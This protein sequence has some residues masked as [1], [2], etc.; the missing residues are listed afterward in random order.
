MTRDEIIAGLLQRGAKPDAARQ[1]ADAYVE[2]QEAADRV[3]TAGLIVAH[4]VTK[5]P[6]EN[7]YLSIR[8]KALARLQAMRKAAYIDVDWLW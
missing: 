6:I 3:T 8:D 5:G 7:P 1:Y 4:P 2:Y